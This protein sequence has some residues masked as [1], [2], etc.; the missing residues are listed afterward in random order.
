MI[1]EQEI[2]RNNAKSTPCYF[3]NLWGTFPSI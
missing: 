3:A 2:C 1:L